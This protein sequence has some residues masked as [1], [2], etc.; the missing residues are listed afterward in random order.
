M[1][2]PIENLYYLLCYAWNTLEEKDRV[3]VSID[4]RTD[5]LDLFAKILINSTRILVKRGVDKSYVPLT[6]E[7]AGIKGKLE[8][9]AT[10]KAHLRLRNRTICSFD[11]FSADILTNRILVSTL[12]RLLKT[13]NLD[14]EFKRDI[15]GLLPVFSDVTPITPIMP[16][17]FSRI[18]LNR[19]NRFY[20]FILNVCRLIIENLRPS[21]TAGEWQFADFTRD[22][23][24]MN[25]LF[26]K[27]IYNFYSHES[28]FNVR[29][30]R[31]GWN[32]SSSNSESMK[33]LPLMITDVTLESPKEKIIIDAKFYRETLVTNYSQQ[34]IRSGHLYQL[35]SYLMNQ[36]SDDSRSQNARGIL[37]YPT[38]EEDHDLDFRYGAHGISIKTV[39]LNSNWR[40]I[41]RRL[42]DLVNHNAAA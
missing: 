25:K 2:I 17:V 38:I 16:S 8:L 40:I 7:F 23:N 15:R 34:K 24:K 26:E 32:L 12:L 18:R 19:N 11:E 4:D 10:V 35:F 9:S 30:E 41:D 5:L 13:K 29:S 1:Q 27:F 33:F 20:G 14:I 31:F 39:N 36:R 42:K 3:A 22:E 21:E 6:E 28:D 37:L